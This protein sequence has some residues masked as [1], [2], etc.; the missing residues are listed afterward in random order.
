M[1]NNS[2]QDLVPNTE[3]SAPTGK[4][5]WF[6]FIGALIPF[7][8]ILCA[9]I[10]GGSN[11]KF[12]DIP[13]LFICIGMPIG[14]SIASAGASDLG[15]ALLALRSLFAPPRESDLT[16]RNAQVLRQMIAYAYTAGVIGSMIGWI[17]ILWQFDSIS[18]IAKWVAVS[19]LTIFY[20]IIISECILRPAA[21]R[22][23]GE[24]EKRNR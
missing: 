20:A 15:R 13:S 6:G 3:I 2:A 7:C 12:F 16:V 18:P 17:Q 8:L 21:R 23:E 5:V 1:F 4:K 14:L 9:I 10:L 24:L 22:I 19:I 11:N